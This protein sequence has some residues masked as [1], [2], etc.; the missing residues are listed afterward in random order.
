MSLIGEEQV[1]AI[2]AIPEFS[3]NTDYNMIDIAKTLDYMNRLYVDTIARHVDLSEARLC[4][5]G[6]GFGWLS[7][8]YLLRGGAAA[9]IVEPHE[10]KLAAARQIAAILDLADRCEFRSDF[11]QEIDLPD[12]SIDVFASIETLEH[13]GKQNIR[14]AIGNIRRLTKSLVVVTTPNLLSPW[15]SH[16]AQVPFSHW[17][18]IPWR[19]GFIRLFGKRYRG[20]NHFAAPWHLMALHDGFRPVSRVLTFDTYQAWLDHYPFYSP[21]GE[22]R[23]KQAPSAAMKAFF[24]AISLLFGRYSFWVCPNMG[25]VWLA[26]QAVGAATASKG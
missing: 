7:F 11:L 25:S 24:G 20:F 16:D 3:G 17:L 22:A 5:C 12:K 10:G 19:D 14:P 4:D 15:V 21:Y 8:T 1:R 26:R 13:V 18:P 9:V 2:Q 6:A 23:I